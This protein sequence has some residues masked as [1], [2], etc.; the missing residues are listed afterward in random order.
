M[1]LSPRPG[2]ARMRDGGSPILGESLSGL[3]LFFHRRLRFISPPPFFSPPPE[4]GCGSI[5]CRY[6]RGAGACDARGPRGWWGRSQTLPTR[7]SLNSSWETNE[8][9]F[10]GRVR[11][12]PPRERRASVRVS[13][14]LLHADERRCT[15]VL[16]CLISSPFLLKISSCLFFFCCFFW[17]KK[18]GSNVF[19]ELG[20]HFAGIWCCR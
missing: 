13:V 14:H 3:H 5:S 1:A 12:S 19:A 8:D 16:V 17:K 2:G 4:D 9:G 6:L 20:R 18:R 11:A 10:G 7:C 15:S